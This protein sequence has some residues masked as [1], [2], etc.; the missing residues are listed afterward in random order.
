MTT[1]FSKV[2]ASLEEVTI[3]YSDGSKQQMTREISL[4]DGASF[5]L[6]M[7]VGALGVWECWMSA[8]VLKARHDPIRLDEDGKEAD[9]EGDYVCVICCPC[10]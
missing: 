3:D 1:E 10:L 6:M 9:T 2:S 4:V 5:A 7:T 8:N